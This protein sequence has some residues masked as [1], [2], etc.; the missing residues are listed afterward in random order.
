MQLCQPESGGWLHHR[1]VTLTFTSGGLQHCEGASSRLHCFQS[2]SS[3]VWKYGQARSQELAMGGCVL[4]AWG[5]SPQQPEAGGLGP[6]T[7]ALENFPFF[8]K[9]NLI[10]RLFS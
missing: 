5:R 1:I 4:G 10:L 2:K 7:P 9:N 8:Y 6:E 3:L